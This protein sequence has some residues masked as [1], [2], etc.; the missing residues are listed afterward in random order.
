MPSDWVFLDQR[1]DQFVSRNPT[2]A[3]LPRSTE[4]AA[5]QTGVWGARNFHSGPILLFWRTIPADLMA[6]E[7][8]CK[9]LAERKSAPHNRV[10]RNYVWG[11][12]KKVHRPIN[13]LVC[14]GV[15]DFKALTVG[16]LR[17]LAGPAT[18]SFIDSSEHH[19]L[20]NADDV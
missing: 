2:Q 18:S 6:Q 10:A 14:G 20:L 15:G 19:L 7:C 16:L 5:S 13:M 1:S 11:R 4:H 3:C 12:G 9:I 17:S 8:S